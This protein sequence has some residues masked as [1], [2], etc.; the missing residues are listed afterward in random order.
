MISRESNEESN[1]QI[2][3]SDSHRMNSTSMLRKPVYEP[4]EN[5]GH[6][7]HFSHTIVIPPPS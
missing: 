3:K 5:N 4:E 2:Q 7:L 6:S 1:C